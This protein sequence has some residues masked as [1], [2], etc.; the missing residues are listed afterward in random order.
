MTRRGLF[1]DL[2]GTLAD[3]LPM[4]RETYHAFLASVGA[5][6]SE[7]EFDRLNGPP[8]GVIIETLK[9]TH[10]LPDDP[11][12]LSARYAGLM[13][14]AHGKARLMDGAEHLLAEARGRGWSVA[15]VTSTA[16]PA[17]EAWLTQRGVDRSVDAIVGG[18]EVEEG[19]P[20]PAPYLLAIER[21]QSDPALSIAVEDSR[22]GATAAVAAGLPTLALTDPG[23]RTDWPV[24]VRFIERLAETVAYL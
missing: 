10:G 18:D 6:G 3:S 2:D 4:L 21:T 22:T 11:D 24:G 17:A 13:R 19:K 14:E 9:Q 12:D 16:R 15:V 20:S 1:L 23:D 8:L 5:R 7:D